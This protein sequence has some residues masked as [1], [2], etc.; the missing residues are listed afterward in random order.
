MEQQGFASPSPVRE[1]P[2]ARPSWWLLVDQQPYG[3]YE[4]NAMRQFVADG[5]VSATTMI[6]RVGTSGWSAAADDGLIF[7]GPPPSH[8]RPSALSVDPMDRSYRDRSAALEGNMKLV[9]AGLGLGLVALFFVPWVNWLVIRPSGFD[10]IQ[11]YQSLHQLAGLSAPPPN[12]RMPATARLDWAKAYLPYLVYLI[13]L[14]GGATATC[15]LGS[16]RL[17]RGFAATSAV[18]TLGLGI[19]AAAAIAD[20]GRDWTALEN[21]VRMTTVGIYGTLIVAAALGIIAIGKR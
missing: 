19:A 3:P 8:R 2:P 7:P 6:C 14:A 21:V 17:W 9:V 5:R 18:V 1:P 10:L 11:Y 20:W 4:L 16:S 12:V 15:A 13:P